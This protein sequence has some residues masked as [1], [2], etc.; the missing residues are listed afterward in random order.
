MRFS[1]RA[2]EQSPG[3][4]RSADSVAHVNL[5]YASGSR[6]NVYS[7]DLTGFR[8]TNA[9]G[10]IATQGGWQASIP[11]PPLLGSSGWLVTAG[12]LVQSV[13]D[14][15]AA[16]EQGLVGN[17]AAA[18]TQVL[19]PSGNAGAPSV[20]RPQT[21]GNVQLLSPWLGAELQRVL[22]R[23]LRRGRR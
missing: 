17:Y 23:G 4:P 9:R 1:R 6:A 10:D 2:R 22:Q 14:R 5:S 16:L 15:V 13:S 12:Y 8:F 20:V 3:S 11:L 21:L 18:L 19:P 7:V